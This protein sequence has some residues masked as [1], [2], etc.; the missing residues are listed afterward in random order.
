MDRV[1]HTAAVSAVDAS[2]DTL[3]RT[4]GR[5]LPRRQAVSL[6]A[7]TLVTGALGRA[8]ATDAAAKGTRK[9]KSSG[10][11]IAA[12]KKRGGRRRQQPLPTTTTTQAPVT[13]TTS[14]P[15]QQPG[16]T[17]TQPPRPSASQL[18]LAVNN[19]CGTQVGLVGTCRTPATGDA[20]AGFDCTSNQVGTN[21][22]SSAQ[23]S[24]NARCVNV[25]GAVNPQCRVVIP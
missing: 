7:A 13:T 1:N 8:V 3:A 24:A 20:R 25:A 14:P 23:C 18:C 11:G 6:L 4:L 22:A 9:N 5:R 2:F 21:C 12:K 19:Q 10:A 16:T 15:I 17:T